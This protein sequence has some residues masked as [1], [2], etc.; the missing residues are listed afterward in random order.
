MDLLSNFNE[1]VQGWKNYVFPDKVVE[2][3]AKERLKICLGCSK[4]SKRY[5]CKICRC[6]M[7]AKVRSPKSNCPINKWI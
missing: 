7:P 6:Y 3:K 2:K 1:I 5:F 4:I